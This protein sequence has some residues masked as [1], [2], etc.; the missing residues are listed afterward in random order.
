MDGGTK[1]I[2]KQDIKDCAAFELRGLP[3]ES[4]MYHGAMIKW[5]ADLKPDQVL[6]A[7]E[8]WEMAPIIREA[9]G[10]KLVVTT[11]LEDAHHI[12]DFNQDLPES[13]RFNGG[14]LYD[15]VICQAILE[16]IY[17]P[18]QFLENL[19]ALVK[20][21]GH[22][23]FH[24]HTPGFNKHDYPIDCLRY[25]PDWFD[26]IAGPLQLDVVRWAE[27]KYNIFVMYRVRPT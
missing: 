1:M 18:Y 4:G 11:G 2:G 17:N 8:Q 13:F 5:A 10:A 3:N 16:H 9:V 6:L 23:L 27:S 25:F 15:L 20:G 14:R 26:V 19:T 24:T 7:G 22:M 12:W 21:N